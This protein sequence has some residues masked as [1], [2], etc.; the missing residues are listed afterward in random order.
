MAAAQAFQQQCLVYDQALNAE[1]YHL[2]Q[3]QQAGY[4]TA[5]A[6]QFVLGPEIVK[7]AVKAGGG[8]VGVGGS[9]VDRVTKIQRR[10]AKNSVTIPGENPNVR[11]QYDLIGA[12]HKGAPTPH[13]QRWVRNVNSKGEVF[14]NKDRKWVR[15]MTDKDL[16]IIEKHLESIKE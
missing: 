15:P 10:V 5:E 16:K 13:V 4:V 2:N 9:F 3:A 11:Y 1:Q 6:L 14:W 8:L 12:S 7:G